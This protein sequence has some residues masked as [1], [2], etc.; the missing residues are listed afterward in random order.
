[1]AGVLRMHNESLALPHIQ[2]ALIVRN[3]GVD[4][5]HFIVKQLAFIE[6]AMG[7]K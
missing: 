4:K 3:L 2:V 1:M 7:I 6:G 5:R